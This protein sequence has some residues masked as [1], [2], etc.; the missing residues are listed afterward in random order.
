MRARAGPA[1]A[2]GFSPQ[3]IA[4]VAWA[5]QTAAHRH[6]ALHDMLAASATRRLREMSA[7]ELGFVL[8]SFSDE[9]LARNGRRPRSG[10]A[11]HRPPWTT[12]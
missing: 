6:D 7:A 4:N 3:A 11:P 9:Q 2:Q 1:P 10:A 5:Y 8:S 12:V